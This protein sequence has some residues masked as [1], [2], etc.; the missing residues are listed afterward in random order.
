MAVNPALLLPAFLVVAGIPFTYSIT[1]GIGLGFIAYVVVMAVL[2]RARSVK[3]LMWVSG[4]AFL[5]MF[6]AS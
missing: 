4:F 6:I 5:I 2:G 3:P 1:D